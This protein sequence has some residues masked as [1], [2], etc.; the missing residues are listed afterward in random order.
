[1]TVVED[2]R[3][4]D[5]ASETVSQTTETASPHKAF[6]PLLSKP[7]T[8]NPQLAALRDIRGHVEV[9]T[10][11]GTWS[12]VLKVRTLSAGDRV[13]TGRLSSVSLDFYDGSQARLGSNTEISIDELDARR[14]DGP[15]VIALTQWLGKSE[16]DVVT[17]AL[18]EGSRYDVHTPGGTGSAKG[19]RF[20]VVVTAAKR[21]HFQ[22]EEGAVAVTGMATTVLVEAG[23]VTTVDV[24]TPPEEPA[25]RIVGEGEVSKIGTPMGE[26]WVIAGQSF[27]VYTDTVIIGGPQIG[28]W[29]SVEGYLS[30]DNT[31]VARVITLL[32]HPPHN[33]FTL[34]GPVET[35][36]DDVWTI[37][38]QSIGISTTTQLAPA[39]ESGDLVR[40]EGLI[41]ED[42]TLQATSISRQD[43]EESGLPFGFTGV[44]QAIDTETW[45]VS[46]VSLAIDGGTQVDDDIVVGDLVR[47]R[48]WIQA[49]GT[50]HTRVI[51]SVVQQP[52][53]FTFTGIV[54]RTDPWQVAGIPFET[55]AWTQID[56]TISVGDTV[57]VRGQ[58]ADDGTWV[59]FE[60]EKFDD[61]ANFTIILIGSLTGIDPWSVNGIPLNV[62]A[63]TITMG[64][65]AVGKLVHVEIERLADGTWRVLKIQPIE[66]GWGQ[67]CLTLKATVISMMGEQIQLDGWPLIELDEDLDVEGALVPG[68]VIWMQVCFTE[69]GGIKVIYMIVIEQPEP[70]E[71]T[72][73]VQED[74]DAKVTI[75]HKPNSKN[76]HTITISRSALPAHLGHGDTLGACP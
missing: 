45:I 54:Q 29:V 40:V 67:G 59:A 8:V 27:T 35:V 36:S 25:F 33:R 6:I 31:R 4:A 74:P 60:I 72:P 1:M 26:P 64:N 69:D 30:P 52:P 62:D 61:E 57:R 3:P 58:I 38:G 5:V 13:R 71:V 75:C 53:M 37:A 9:Q 48:G 50:W 66:L 44:V 51:E 41:L 34:V 43:E 24:D 76:P 14:E 56:E 28:D 23:E 19:T 47:V 10:E 12:S 11:T 2:G 7:L 20:Y 65:L 18:A 17:P 68:S 55:R 39:I 16:H 70:E 21:T 32:R 49:D 22:V 73:P 42:G 46:G 15:R 63:A